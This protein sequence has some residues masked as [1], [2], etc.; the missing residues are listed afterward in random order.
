MSTRSTSGFLRVGYYDDG[1][2]REKGRGTY[3]SWLGGRFSS[4]SDMILKENLFSTLTD[5]EEI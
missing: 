3:W 1:G 4:S 2:E 5:P